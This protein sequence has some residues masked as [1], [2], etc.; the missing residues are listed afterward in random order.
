MTFSTDHLDYL[1]RS[2]GL[3][4]VTGPL[5]SAPP[6]LRQLYHI[7]SV[8][9]IKKEPSQK[10]PERIV[11]ED[12]LIGAYG[13]KIPL[14]FLVQGTLEGVS[15]YMGTWSPMERE[16]ASPDTL[17]Q[18]QQILSTLLTSIY[19]A[20]AITP[21]DVQV[22]LLPLS[23]LVLGTPTAKR[24]PENALPLDRLIRAMS[25]TRYTCLILAEP[26]DESV[27]TALRQ[28][29]INEMRSAQAAA[30][31]TK[32]PSPLAQHY[33]ELL[34]VLL[35]TMTFGQ[36]V[37]AWRTAV[38]LLGDKTSYYQLASVWRS[39][40]SGDTSLPEPI[41]VWDYDKVRELADKW[42]MPDTPMPHGPGA[43]N[44]LFQ[45]QT[46]LTSSQLCACIHLP[47]KEA[48]G[49]AVTIVPDFDTVPPPVTG[50][51]VDIG[52]ILHRTRPTQNMYAV[53][54][55]T[56]KRHVLTAGVTG[57]GKTNTVF[58]ILIQ[59]WNCGIPFLVLEPAKTEYRS[60]LTH[61]KVGPHLRIFTLGHEQVSP[62]RLNP[63]EVEPGVPVSTHIDLLKSVFNAS[64]G[65][66]TPLP[67]VLERCIHAVYQDKGWDPVRNVNHRL[68][69]TLI[70]DAYPT[71]T[72]LYKKVSDVVNRLGYEAKVTSDIK[73]A[74][75]T[76]LNSLRIGGKGVMLDT[77]QSIPTTELLSNPTI[78]ELEEIG[79]DDEK[80]FVMG[81]LLTKVYEYL[82]AHKSTEGTALRHITV[83]EEA[84]RLLANVPL[85]V[86][87][88]YA[89][90]K[91][92]A[93][94][95]FTNMLSEVRAYGEGF[96]V[97]E[98]IP[99]KLSPDV[100]KNTNLKI[101]HRIVAGDDRY[102]LGQTMNMDELQ[103][104]LLSTVKTGQAAVFSEGDDHPLLVKVPY[105][106]IKVPPNMETK[107]GSDSIV[108][109]LMEEF[110]AQEPIASL[111]Y[112]F[113]ACRRICKE[114]FRYCADAKEIVGHKEFQEQFAAFVL[115][116]I[117]GA[118]DTTYSQLL[119]Y[120]CSRIPQRN[121][122]PDAVACI[123]L[124]GIHWYF[125]YFGRQ[126]NWLY[127][128]VDDL[129][130]LLSPIV[131]KIGSQNVE[132]IVRFQT[133]YKNA[134]RRLQDP[135]PACPVVCPSGDCLFRYHTALLLYDHRLTELFNAGMTTAGSEP[136]WKDVRAVNQVIARLAADMS[137]NTQ[138]SIGL[139]YGV[140][141]ITYKPGLLEQARNLAIDKLI[142]SVDALMTPAGKGGFT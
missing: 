17:M 50:E 9:C 120:I 94:E 68:S 30:E 40:F 57:S 47:H 104:A 125:T 24:E 129:K 99:S 115:S 103:H 84:H 101:V 76:R 18:R 133:A 55:K 15:I 22:P 71:L 52:R 32:A 34:Q 6:N 51:T 56:L 93:V 85:S 3:P 31:A 134:C 46:L 124:Q 72:D 109:T 13:Y 79:D 61:E 75:M 7:K 14:A 58:H 43:Y 135:F 130:K 49:F 138:R 86:N 19:P 37:G 28:N 27:I 41:R 73:A 8:G 23:G 139:C 11:S 63:F 38:Y 65:M 25:H 116:V 141:Q 74:L 136:E 88:E 102:I 64:F 39:I 95:T 97:A 132:E 36:A 83:I 60:L 108:K 45:Y 62:F 123:L 81:L 42:A 98:Q 131:L 119:T 77:A 70:H 26:V 92:K 12:I 107:H 10:Q 128:C 118:P 106:K 4:P 35:E 89:N 121:T 87:Q 96:I 29:I 90:I 110:R 105:A 82:R 69:D 59:L 21:A 113:E 1:Q 100:I 80:A 137:R 33:T 5:T 126:Y 67:Q 78:I 66:W 127:T 114:P 2:G 122:T 54:T 140:Q 112:P 48:P 44:H 142:H 20:V 16:N 117:E 91:G 111:Y 53:T